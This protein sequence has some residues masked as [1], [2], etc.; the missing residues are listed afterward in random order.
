MLKNSLT[1]LLIALTCTLISCEKEITLALPPPEL[2]LVVEGVI[3]HDLPPIVLLTTNRSY[4]APVDFAS[5]EAAQVHNANITVSNGTTTITLTEFCCSTLPD[6]LQAIIINQ[7]GLPGL[8]CPYDIC[9]YTNISGALVGTANTTYKLK[10]DALGMNINAS[11]YMPPKNNID[12]VWVQYRNYPDGGIATWT[13]DINNA[14]DSLV[15]LMNRVTDAPLLG[16]FYMYYTARNSEPY[17]YGSVYDDKFINN[18]S[19]D[20]PRFR[21][22]PR[23]AAFNDESGLFKRGD[24]IKLKWCTIDFHTYDF[25]STLEFELNGQGSPFA[26]PTIIKTNINGGLGIWKAV[27]PNYYSLI[28]P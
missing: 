28:A 7:L 10:I 11:T 4:F 14:T 19:F 15:R 18:L 9:I 22:Q 5:I 27:N 20:V 13:D 1:I 8:T 2:K 26:S 21:A 17:Y 24:T 6:S 16:D 23:S 25:H 3:E 12:S